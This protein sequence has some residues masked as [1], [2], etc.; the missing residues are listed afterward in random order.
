MDQRS[1][2]RA[3]FVFAKVLRDDGSPLPGPIMVD[4]VCQGS[5]HKQAFTFDEG[6]FGFSLGEERSGSSD[7]SVSGTQSNRNDPFSRI[8]GQ[9]SGTMN[10]SNCNVRSGLPRFKSDVI[11]LDV[12][13]C[14]KNADVGTLVLRRLGQVQGLTVSR[15]G[16]QRPKEGT[17]SVRE[18]R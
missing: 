2:D 15:Y 12:I 10:L 6:S 3:P 16:S 17:E 4:L 14:V 8:R 1:V 9:E 5:V 11:G 18:G 7:A 13:R